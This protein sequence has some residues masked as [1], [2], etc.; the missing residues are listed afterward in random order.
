MELKVYE[1]DT[2]KK[3]LLEKVKFKKHTSIQTSEAVHVYQMFV[4][5]CM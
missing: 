2:N 1:K 5:K 3:F 4:K